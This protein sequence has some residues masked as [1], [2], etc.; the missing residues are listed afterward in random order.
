MADVKPD[1]K[2]TY[3]S[4]KKPYLTHN[5]RTMMKKKTQEEYYFHELHQDPMSNLLKPYHHHPEIPG[6]GWEYMA[7]DYDWGWPPWDYPGPGPGGGGR[8]PYDDDDGIPPGE[9][10]TE[11]KIVGPTSVECGSAWIG[12]IIPSECA[13]FI[14][15]GMGLEDGETFETVATST[16]AI[17]VAVPEDATSPTLFVCSSGGLH[18]VTCCLEVEIECDVEP[19][20]CEDFSLTGPGS[21]AAGANWVGVISPACP[22]LAENC[23]EV[24]VVSNSGCTGLGCSISASG[25]QLTISGTSG[26]CGSVTV[27]I[28]YDQPGEECDTDPIVASATFRITGAGDWVIQTTDG[29]GPACQEGGCGCGCG[30]SSFGNCI[31]EPLKYGSACRP[32]TGADCC[33]QGWSQQCKGANPPGCSDSNSGAPCGPTVSCASAGC[34]CDGSPCN[35]GGGCCCSRHAFWICEWECTCT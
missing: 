21:I 1:Q 25:A 22:E 5:Y 3:Y 15:F 17:V 16:G 19:D 24:A 26:K 12:Q 14:A 9:G 31:L 10:C 30:I 34:T 7:P 23:D 28:T 32:F 11:C 35:V 8:G 18:G 4:G 33:W 13:G 27:T 29:G 2:A 6:F 20:C